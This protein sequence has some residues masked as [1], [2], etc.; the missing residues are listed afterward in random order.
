MFRFLH[1]S[2]LHL[3]KPFGRF[4]EETRVRLRE[5]RHTRIDRLAQ[6]ARDEGATH[7]LLAGDTFDAETPPPRTVR[8]AMQAMASNHDIGWVM[9]PGN[10]DSLAATDLWSRLSSECPDNLMLT[11]SPEIVMLQDEVALLPAPPTVRDPGRDLTGWMEGAA[12]SDCLRIGLAHGGVQSFGDD[13]SALDVIPPDRDRTAGLDYLALGDWHGAMRIS[14][15]CWYSGTPE[16]DNF[17][18]QARPQCLVV[19]LPGRSSTPSVKRVETGAFL[20]HSARVDLRPEDDIEVQI[21]DSLPSRG[22]RDALVKIEIAGRLGLSERDR[23][24]AFLAACQ[25]DFAHFEADLDAVEIASEFVD[26]DAIDTSGA[27]RAAANR[28]LEKASDPRPEEAERAQVSKLAL[29]RLY[30]FAKEIEA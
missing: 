6:I 2:D 1:S 20:W 15:R 22:R 7:V 30:R 19:S 12:T 18:D 16:G 29:A 5:A 17:K 13:A 9:M 3:G 24:E 11:L 25:D 26:L 23:A 4:D 28:L 27:L 14:D 21:G 8:Q 10:H